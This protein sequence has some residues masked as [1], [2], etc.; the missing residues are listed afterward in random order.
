MNMEMSAL[1]GLL[2]HLEEFLMLDMLDGSS[3]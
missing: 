2:R 1:R 3:Q